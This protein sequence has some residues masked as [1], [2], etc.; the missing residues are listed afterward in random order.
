MALRA[1]FKNQLDL[2][3][4]NSGK[5]IVEKKSNQHLQA[6]RLSAEMLR[7]FEKNFNCPHSGAFSQIFDILLSG[8]GKL[9]FDSKVLCDLS[10]YE[11]K[12]MF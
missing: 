8:Y 4:K 11:E 7:R 2:L 5:N 9:N 6:D 10:A 1:K 3:L 12:I